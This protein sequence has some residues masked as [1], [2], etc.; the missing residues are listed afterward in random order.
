LKS[1]LQKSA[2]I[3][4]TLIVCLVVG[5]VALRLFTPFPVTSN[6]HKAAH[7]KLGYTFE[8]ALDDIDEHGFRNLPGAWERRD[9]AVI[10]DSH[11]YGYGVGREGNFASQLA[12]ATGRDVYNFGIGSYGIYQYKVLVDEALRLGFKDVVLALFPANDVAPTCSSTQN[13]YWRDYARE[14]NIEIAPCYGSP[15]PTGLRR[16][17]RIV[18]DA[19]KRSATVDAVRVLFWNRVRESVATETAIGVRDYYLFREGIVIRR[20]FVAALAGGASLDN[21]GVRLT[22][23][24]S[25]RFLAEGNQ[26]LKARGIGFVVI[27]VPSRTAIFH[28][29]AESEGFDLEPEFVESVARLTRLTAAYR[30]FFEANGIAY[31]D[32]H[33]HVL[34]A[35]RAG[36]AEGRKIYPPG[37]GHPNEQG[38]RA[39]AQAAAEGLRLTG[40]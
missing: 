18:S 2:T 8:P 38:Y 37:D 5:E 25:K 31:V 40:R 32:A 28:A 39:Y 10:G 30:E 4:A 15:Y 20:E 22:F 27:L 21:P 13:D 1:F 11:A 16:Y 29:W 24:N 17:A 34:A 23:E 36:L 9:I 7:A 6:L 3:F 33:P 35:F 19:L 12:E 14:N 26:A